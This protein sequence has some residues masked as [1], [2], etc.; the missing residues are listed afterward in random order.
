MLFLHSLETHKTEGPLLALMAAIM[1]LDEPDLYSPLLS[2][3]VVR[4]LRT[5]FPEMDGIAEHLD[6]KGGKCLVSKKRAQASILGEAKADVHDKATWG[7]FELEHFATA[8]QITRLHHSVVDLTDTGKAN[9]SSGVDFM[10]VMALLTEMF[11]EE[12]AGPSATATAT[13]SL[14]RC[15]AAALLP[16][17]IQAA[18]LSRSTYSYF[19]GITHR[20]R[21]FLVQRK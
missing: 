15:Y 11:L 8:S 9:G 7:C 10:V 13:A 3:V 21:L 18:M 2:H 20:L 16:P 19:H 6:E 14:L 12:S 4:A 5:A 1:G 17:N